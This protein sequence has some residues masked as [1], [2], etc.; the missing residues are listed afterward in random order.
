MLLSNTS[1]ILVSDYKESG[2][3]DIC[4]Y[5][6]T[7]NKEFQ[8]ANKRKSMICI[9]CAR[10]LAGRCVECLTQ[11]DASPGKSRHV[12]IDNKKYCIKCFQSEA[13]KIYGHGSQ[14][15]SQVRVWDIATGRLLESPNKAN[16]VV[17]IH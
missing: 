15:T 6:S 17:T 9:G 4:K 14:A 10:K 8:D 5:Y 3:C 2:R 13:I 11:L 7:M 1:N 16:N 12:L